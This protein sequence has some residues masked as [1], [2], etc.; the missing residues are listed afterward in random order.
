MIVAD[1]YSL[2]HFYYYYVSSISK[3]QCEE[4][5]LLYCHMHIKAVILRVTAFATLSLIKKAWNNLLHR[6][7]MQLTASGIHFSCMHASRLFHSL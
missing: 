7:I 2:L 3:L 6:G 5:I 1:S 4:E